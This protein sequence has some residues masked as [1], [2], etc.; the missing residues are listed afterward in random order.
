MAGDATPLV[1]LRD[2][3]PAAAH[4]RR[5]D[6]AARRAADGRAVRARDAFG[7][8][9]RLD[10]APWLGMRPCTPDMRP[11]IGAAPRHRHLWF[12]FGHCHH[13]LTLGPRPGG[14]SPR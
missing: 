11:V 9:E 2:G 5:R 1:Q 6:R 14:C 7:I 3:W 13:E 12:A 8:G 10:P 4:D